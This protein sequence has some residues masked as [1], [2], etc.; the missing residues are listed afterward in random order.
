MMP[1]TPR[2]VRTTRR[3]ARLT[4]IEVAELLEVTRR[5]VYSWENGTHPMRP[6]LYNYLLLKLSER[7][8]P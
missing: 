8:C 6:C 3:H 4:V 7:T 2:Q 5:T 1:P